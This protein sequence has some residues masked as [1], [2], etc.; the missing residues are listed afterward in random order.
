MTSLSHLLRV[1]RYRAAGRLLTSLLWLCTAST[2]V[3]QAEPAGPV[4]S[5]VDHVVWR[6]LDRTRPST[7]DELLPRATPA[8]YTAAELAELERRIR[9]L[10]VFDNVEMRVEDRTLFVN[11]REKWT[12]VPEF[13][14][15]TGTTIRDLYVLLGATEHNFLGVASSLGV[16]AYHEQR[17]FGFYLA[18][19]EH[20]YRRNRWALAAE[21]SYET[22]EYRFGDGASWAAR[23]V[24]LYPWTTSPPL[25]S[26]HAR[27]E[28]GLRYA[29]QKVREFEGPSRPEDGHTLG[30][31]AML[32]WDQ[33][34]WHDLAPGGFRAG[35]CFTPGVFIGDGPLRERGRVDFE[36]A[37]SLPFTQYTALVSQVVGSGV[38]LGHPNFSVLI[39]SAEGV[40]G[41]EDAWYF[42]WAQAYSNIEL[43]QA[44]PLGG[45]WAIQLVGFADVG[46]FARM[47]SLGRQDLSY[48]AAG[49]GAGVRVVPTWISTIVPR[50]D[51]ARLVAPTVSTFYQFGLSQYF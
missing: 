5:S 15:A 2:S 46:A 3:A 31:S 25:G 50:F 47:D 44:I 4:S 41:L 7:L 6:G 38:S 21:A 10:E 32:T 51:V 13:D 37:A 40:R 22:A 9:N 14:L 34:E 33:Y 19:E 48:F 24:V 49:G 45:R 18:Y 28:L 12:L 17:G 27:L 23:E 11:L 36:V 42:N 26:D 16:N 20:V 43:R 29:H 8:V 30:V 1:V 35:L 39:G